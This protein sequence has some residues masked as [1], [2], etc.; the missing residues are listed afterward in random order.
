MPHSPARRSVAACLTAV[1]AAPLAFAQSPS[2]TIAPDRFATAVHSGTANDRADFGTW[3]S[4]ADFKTSFHDGFAFYPLL[5]PARP[6]NLPVRWTTLHVRVGGEVVAVGGAEQ[7]F[8]ANAHRV[9][10]RHGAFDEVYDVRDDGVEQSFVF[11]RPLGGAG[12]LVVTGLVATELTCADAQPASQPLV[13][14]DDAG[15]AIV[16]YGEACV[17]DAVGRRA[18]VTTARDG[19]RVELRI[20]ADFLARATYPIR[21]DPLIS[22]VELD[23][24]V[25]P[26]VDLDVIVAPDAGAPKLLVVYTRAFAGN[27]VDAFAF[28]AGTDFTDPTPVFADVN[29]TWSTK[30]G[31]ASYAG[32]AQRWAMVFERELFAPTTSS[33]IA[34]FHDRDDVTLNSGVTT[35]LSKPV[36]T[37]ARNPDVGGRRPG[38]G[39]NV[40]VVY[41]TDVTATQQNTVNSET[42]GVLVDAATAAETS[43]PNTL[44]WFGAGTTYDREFPTVVKMSDGAPGYWIVSWMEFFSLASPDDWDI[45]V[46][47]FSFDGFHQAQR[48]RFGVSAAPPHKRYPQM[49]GGDGR[50]LMAMT[51]G[52]GLTGV[53]ADE[54]HV[55]RFDW[56]DAQYDPVMGP[57]VPIA[58]DPATPD[59]AFPRVAFDETTRSHWAVT[60]QRGPTTNGDLFVRRVAADGVVVE[61][62]TLFQSPT[63]AGGAT[64]VAFAPGNGGSFP[65]VYATD[66]PGAPVFGTRL[67]YPAGA[68]NDVYGVGCG[69]TIDASP[70]YLGSEFFAITL[71]GAEANQ[72]AALGLSAVAMSTPVPLLPP[73]CE[74]QIG[75]GDW[76]LLLTGPGGDAAVAIPLVTSLPVGLEVYTQWL[77]VQTTGSGPQVLATPGLH[78]RI[79]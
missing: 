2:A 62:Q 48:Y 4:G 68:A 11:A 43:T 73:G 50:F 22:R 58:Q 13:F 1:I 77:H 23:S 75:V 34:C 47:R 61:A 57:P 79:E 66:E 36:G 51:Y 24:D 42:W 19:E 17:F 37:T 45:N 54:V 41:Q 27:D 12:D 65:I 14:F 10:Y 32:D 52:G 53:T 33:V 7:P 31:R 59:F 25:A 46:T 44:D 55:Q 39:A 21:L 40:L 35:T 67:T 74:L 49:A 56:P 78:T 60:W 16:R 8:V 18:A 64:A 71:A 9:V 28:V 26:V 15:D 70:P 76:L 3:A 20:A 5:G 29:A 72:L 38:G 69:G 6:R 30:R 63:N